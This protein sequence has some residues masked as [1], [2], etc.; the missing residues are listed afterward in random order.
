VRTSLFEKYWDSI[1]ND[2]LEMD[3]HPG[4]GVDLGVCHEGRNAAMRTVRDILRSKGTTVWSVS[5][6]ESVYGALS[7]MA[8]KNIGAVLV[9]ENDRLAGIF[10]ERDYARKVDLC[11]KKAQGTPVR[12]IMTEQVVGVRPEETVEECM[13]LMTDKHVRHLPVVDGGEVIGV[14]SIGDVVKS[15]ISE[16]EFIID[17]LETYITGTPYRPR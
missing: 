8:D 9:M 5:P 3:E 6:D 17:Q 4:T 7:L 15:I 16:Q 10:S 14:I 11:G 13:A 2:H 1:G 12:D